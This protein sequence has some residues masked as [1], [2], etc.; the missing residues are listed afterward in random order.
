MRNYLD[1]TTV[2]STTRV[3][4]DRR[5]FPRFPLSAFAEIVEA[6]SHTRTSARISELSRTGC[7]AEMLSPFP[8][9]DL[10]KMRIMKNKTSF[11]AQ[12]E[13][14]NTSFWSGSL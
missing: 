10:V 12:A 14:T 13:V 8:L 6:Q 2:V 4:N 5:N 7:Y 3:L 1:R 9:G 11:L